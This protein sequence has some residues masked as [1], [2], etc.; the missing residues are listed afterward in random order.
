VPAPRRLGRVK[1]VLPEPEVL[2][3][4]LVEVNGSLVFTA[5]LK[6]GRAVAAL[7]RALGVGE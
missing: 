3:D 1:I 2:P 7:S 6:P 5:T 4:G